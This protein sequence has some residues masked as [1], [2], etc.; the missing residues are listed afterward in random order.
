MFQTCALSTAH[1]ITS[2]HPNARVFVI[3]ETG[4]VQALQDEGNREGRGER[5]NYSNV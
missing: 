1:F 5:S 2:Q 4:L 3:G